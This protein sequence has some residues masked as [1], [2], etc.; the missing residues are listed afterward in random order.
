[1]RS[2]CLSLCRQGPN[3]VERAASLP[4]VV[5]PRERWAKRAKWTTAELHG[6]VA[7]SAGTQ[8]NGPTPPRPGSPRSWPGCPAAPTRSS[9]RAPPTPASVGARQRR[10]SATQ[11][12]HDGSALNSAMPVIEDHSALQA[13]HNAC[14][15]GDRGAERLDPG[16]SATPRPQRPVDL[17]AHSAGV[18][19]SLRRGVPGVPIASEDRFVRAGHGWCRVR[20]C[21]HGR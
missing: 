11:P 1:V 13:R 21:G 3:A 18:V 15:A 7:K 4:E 10:W 6:R 5:A 19:P 2:P 9:S 8:A 20:R 16:A 17:H 12:A 14:Y